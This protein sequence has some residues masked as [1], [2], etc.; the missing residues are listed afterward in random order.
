MFNNLLN[1]SNVKEDKMKRILLAVILAALFQGTH[2][3]AQ[4][5]PKEMESEFY[6]YN[7]TIERIYT[8]RLGYM[9]LYRNGGNKLAHTFIP[10]EWFNT[11]GGKGEIVYLGPG[12]E[13]PSMI[14]Y[15]QNGSFSHVRLRIRKSRTHETW[16]MIPMHVNMDE[17]FRDIEE[18]KLD[19]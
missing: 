19:F 18:V 2:L 15:Y 3:F 11:I 9:V 7:F 17:H 6:Y 12:K 10:D 1:I 8:H 5:I 13:W 4:V 16:G 14:V